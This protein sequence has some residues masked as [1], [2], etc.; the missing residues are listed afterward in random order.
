MPQVFE[1]ARDAGA[2][3]A[4]LYRFAQL[5]MDLYDEALQIAGRTKEPV[6]ISSE[7]LAPALRVFRREPAVPNLKAS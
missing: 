6:S 1:L 7:D 2:D 5:H 4:A 3:S